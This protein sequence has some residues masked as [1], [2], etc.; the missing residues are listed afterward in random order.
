NPSLPAP[1]QAPSLSSC[2]KRK[3]QEL[4]PE[5]RIPGFECNRS[6]PEGV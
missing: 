6:L 3:A 5:V 1:K 4:E 2:R